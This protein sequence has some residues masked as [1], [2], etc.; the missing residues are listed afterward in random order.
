M[1]FPKVKLALIFATIIGL[2]VAQKSWENEYLN[3]IAQAAELV[4]NNSS[5][6]EESKTEEFEIV[7]E[8]SEGL[9][10]I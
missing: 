8:F 1:A 7:G 9:A 5:N 10:R 4:E 3:D 6:I 2:F